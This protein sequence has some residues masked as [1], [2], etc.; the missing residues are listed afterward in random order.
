M[1]KDVGAGV[2]APRA[3]AT[4]TSRKAAHVLLTERDLDM[5]TALHDHVVLSFMQIHERFFPARTIATAMN[6]LKRIES[7]GWIERLRIPRLRIEGRANATGVVFQLPYLGRTMLARARPEVAIFEKCPVL[8]PYQLD[9]DLLIADIAEH[10]KG[11]FPGYQWT[12]GRYLLDSDGF[13]KI[14]DAVLQR[15]AADRAIAIELELNGKSARRYRD[16]IATFRTSPRIEKVIYVTANHA[17]GRKIMSAIE[18]Y[19]VPFGHRFRSEFFEF[20]RLSE[21]LKDKSPKR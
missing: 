7:Q 20:V 3:N 5:M 1:K 8:N 12:N 18:G 13:K 15:T 21:C 10:F 19:Q 17:I 11:R 9:H 14:P 6:R 4:L 16:I 2:P